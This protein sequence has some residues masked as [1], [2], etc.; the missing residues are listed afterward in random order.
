M[1]NLINDSQFTESS[2]KAQSGVS[3]GVNQLERGWLDPRGSHGPEIT[4]ISKPE[5][6]GTMPESHNKNGPSNLNEGLT[7]AMQSQQSKRTYNNQS[8]PLKKKS[9][10]EQASNKHAELCMGGPSFASTA[11]NS[12][13]KVDQFLIPELDPTDAS[14][15]DSLL[16]ILDNF[17]NN[18][19]NLSALSQGPKQESEYLPPCM[20]N[21][22]REDKMTEQYLSSDNSLLN[23]V[24]LHPLDHMQTLL[25]KSHLSS[26]SYIDTSQLPSNSLQK[27]KKEVHLNHLVD[28]YEKLYRVTIN[29]LYHEFLLL[30]ISPVE[31]KKIGNL[32][33]NF[34]VVPLG[35]DHLGYESLF[36]V[37]FNSKGEVFN[38]ETLIKN[39]R[40]LHLS[41]HETHSTLWKQLNTNHLSTKD[42]DF[43]EIMHWLFGEVFNPKTKIPLM[44]RTQVKILDE[45]KFSPV[46]F[47]VMK[48]L[49]E[50]ESLEEL[51]LEIVRIWFQMHSDKWEDGNNNSSCDISNNLTKQDTSISLGKMKG[52]EAVKSKMPFA[53]DSTHKIIN[54]THC[55]AFKKVWKVNHELFLEIGNFKL[56]DVYDHEPRKNINVENRNFLSW[57]DS[58][59][60][61]VEPAKEKISCSI[62]QECTSLSRQ[63]PILSTD[64][65]ETIQDLDIAITTNEFNHHHFFVMPVY[66]NNKKIVRKSQIKIKVKNI[67]DSLEHY[68][69]LIFSHL[70]TEGSK[71]DQISQSGFLEWFSERFYG[72]NHPNLK[73]PIF[74]K[75]ERSALNQLSKIEYDDVQ[76]LVIQKFHSKRKYKYQE[77]SLALLG[78]WFKNENPTFWN[79]YFKTDEEYSKFIATVIVNHKEEIKFK[80]FG[81]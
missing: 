26:S 7:S 13:G 50:P 35:K 2:N 71:P 40:D 55:G 15:N 28:K 56:F 81:I 66:P 57:M 45:V 80:K 30:P 79:E 33:V 10:I 16:E 44:G 65:P 53:N 48:L 39:F 36:L 47:G 11:E 43:Q 73:F 51:S 5:S 25:P 4:S 69:G 12:Q 74:G 27:N 76:T 19:E 60:S 67:C 62:I 23:P 70:L 31:V 29:Q 32:S 41:L 63:Y 20:Q 6:A 1:E 34:L 8:A 77:A 9:K 54:F 78:Y 3:K 18:H 14:S 75:F 49:E 68:S 24:L 37:P 64:F 22:E 42:S 52:L 21:P 46:Q 59:L 61:K 17:F 58:S 38:T 72:R